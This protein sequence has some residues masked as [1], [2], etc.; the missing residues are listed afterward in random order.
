[1]IVFPAEALDETQ[2]EGEARRRRR[3]TRS[4]RRAAGAGQGRAEEGKGEASP[5]RIPDN[6]R[7][8]GA[9]GA[10]ESDI[11][12][13]ERESGW[14]NSATRESRERR[15][16]RRRVSDAGGQEKGSSTMAMPP[17]VPDG[18][19]WAVAFAPGGLSTLTPG[20]SGVE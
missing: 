3:T 17:L 10:V 12:D 6:R 1:M 7:R 4:S 14:S 9:E 8:P 18:E 11:G 13:V 16:G 19:D 15:A 5:N 20:V 2:H